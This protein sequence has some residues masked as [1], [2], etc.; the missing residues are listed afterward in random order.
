MML[1]V[2]SNHLF[3][4][5]LVPSLHIAVVGYINGAKVD[6]RVYV[7]DVHYDKKT[8]FVNYENV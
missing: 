7:G 1:D 3:H 2:I 6:I 8:Y 4:P 5:S